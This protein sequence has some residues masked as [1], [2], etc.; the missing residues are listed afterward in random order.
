MPISASRPP[1]STRPE[2]ALIEDAFALGVPRDHGRIRTLRRVRESRVLQSIGLDTQNRPQWMTPRAARAWARM[3]DAALDD[4]VTLQM[5]SAFRSVEYQLGIVRRKLERGLSMGEIL[6]VS[7][8][9]GFSEH[10]SGRAFDLTTPGFA[11]LEEEFEKSAA[12]AWLRRHAA[13]FG[14]RMSYPRRNPH[15]IAYEPWH[16]CWHARK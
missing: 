1:L 12:F 16:W 14:F 2:R 6:R 8:A 5:V 3:R 13:K 9:P 15:G 10:H 11:A 4:G 7:A